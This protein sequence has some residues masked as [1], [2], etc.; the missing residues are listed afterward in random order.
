[1][2][3]FTFCFSVYL[4]VIFFNK[5]YEILLK[6]IYNDICK[7]LQLDF[8]LLSSNI[9][10]KVRHIITRYRVLYLQINVSVSF[11]IK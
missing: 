5:Y 11:Y 4:T 2:N 3:L 6:L 8:I 1:M 9:D 10:V 7:E